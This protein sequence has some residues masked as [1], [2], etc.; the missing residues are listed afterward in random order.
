[1]LIKIDQG[2][3]VSSVFGFFVTVN[4]QLVTYERVAARVF[5]FSVYALRSCNSQAIKVVCMK[6]SEHN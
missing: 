3:K 2:Q 1:M 5:V 6:F 4:V